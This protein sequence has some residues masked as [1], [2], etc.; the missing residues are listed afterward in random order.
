MCYLP[1]ADDDSL[2]GIFRTR[3]HE[4]RGA[5][6]HEHRRDVAVPLQQEARG[7][8]LRRKAWL[9]GHLAVAHAESAESAHDRLPGSACGRYM[10]ALLGVAL[11]VEEIDECRAAEI[12]DCAAGVADLNAHN[13]VDHSTERGLMQR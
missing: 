5:M 7:G 12:L 1:A 4:C 3:Q 8:S 11:I 13:G 2:A 6:T 9:E 10:D